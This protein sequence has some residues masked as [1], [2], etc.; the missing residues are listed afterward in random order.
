MGATMVETHWDRKLTRECE[1]LNECGSCEACRTVKYNRT[2]TGLSPLDEVGSDAYFAAI[3]AEARRATA[4]ETAKVKWPKVKA[5]K[6]SRRNDPHPQACCFCDRPQAPGTEVW[7]HE[8]LP[9]V[10]CAGCAK[11][12]PSDKSYNYPLSDSNWKCKW[13]P[14]VIGSDET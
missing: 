10:S 9:V 11:R 5:P 6:A 1:E 8:R 13:L 12:N 2:V 7:A 4:P 3:F 14:A